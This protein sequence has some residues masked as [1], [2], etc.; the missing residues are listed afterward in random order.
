MH[1]KEILVYI[2]FAAVGIMLAFLFGALFL[3]IIFTG[4]TAFQEIS[5]ATAASASLLFAVT[6]MLGYIAA[7]LENHQRELR[8]QT[9]YMRW[10]QETAER[11]IFSDVQSRSAQGSMSAAPPQHPAAPY[12]PR[13]GSNPN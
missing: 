5:A 6:M 12:T 1:V 4:G 3:V 8:K 10:M 7:L 9:A 13:K 2:L 11:M